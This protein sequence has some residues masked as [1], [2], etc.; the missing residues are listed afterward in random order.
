[1]FLFIEP[2]F[3][4]SGTFIIGSFKWSSS[5][6]ETFKKK[7]MVFKSFKKIETKKFDVHNYGI[8]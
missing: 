8:Y 2:G 3:L 7:K 4:L 5:S 6:M 1:M